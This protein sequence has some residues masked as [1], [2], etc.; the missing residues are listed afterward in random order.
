MFRVVADKMVEEAGITPLLHCLAVEAVMEGN[1]N[2]Y[3]EE[4]DFSEAD[5]VVPELGIPRT[6]RSALID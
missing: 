4:E 2:G 5:L 1:T 3:T 6:F